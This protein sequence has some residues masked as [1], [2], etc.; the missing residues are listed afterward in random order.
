[1]ITLMIQSYSWML[2]YVRIRRND[3][4]QSPDRVENHN[5]SDDSKLQTPDAVQG[6]TTKESNS[7]L[8]QHQLH[9]ALAL[10]ILLFR[11]CAPGPGS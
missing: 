7:A 3:D 9:E 8:R 11:A 4:G 1:M 5:E 2:S 6:I 10:A